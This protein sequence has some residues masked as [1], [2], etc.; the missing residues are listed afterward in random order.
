MNNMKRILYLA[1]ILPFI[2]ISCEKTPVAHFST[3][4]IEPE[5]G[6]E[7][8]FNNDS[9]NATKFEWDFGDGYISND[10][11]PYHVY[12]STGTFEV[13]LKAISK[14][15]NEDQAS[16]T[17]TVLI[18]TL[19][20]IEV[21]EWNNEAVVV[22]DASII[23]YNS[24]D[25]W[26]ANDPEKMVIEG[27]TD[28]NGLAV[29]ANLEPFVYYVDVYETTHDNWDFRNLVDNILYIRTP[30]V[31]SHQ[32]NWFIAWVDIVDHGKGQTRGTRSM[33]I[34]KIERKSAGK[35]QPEAVSGTKDW[36]TLYNMRSGK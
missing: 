22:P 33:I 14:N 10:R 4:T 23:L 24:L 7:V 17:L 9:Q 18:P 27:F 19:L 20:V 21:R 6:H 26:D 34:R 2:L 28:I 5:V 35:P 11:N 30:E 13:N 25:D 1:L 29:F 15:G 8:L 16:L 32:I 36:E 3:D 31:M 12:N